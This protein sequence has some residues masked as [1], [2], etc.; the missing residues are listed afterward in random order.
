MCLGCRR[1]DR[2]FRRLKNR[3]EDRYRRARAR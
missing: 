2:D 3:F 1:Y